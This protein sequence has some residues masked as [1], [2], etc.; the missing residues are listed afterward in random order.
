MGDVF[1]WFLPPKREPTKPK[2]FVAKIPMSNFYVDKENKLF[3][4]S[5]NPKEISYLCNVISN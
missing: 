4:I 3:E 1:E 2:K 5:Y